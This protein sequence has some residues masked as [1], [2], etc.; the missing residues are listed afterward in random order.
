MPILLAGN[1]KPAVVGGAA[2]LADGLRERAA[3]G[4]QHVG[5]HDPRAGSREHAR[6]GRPLP[7][8]AA[9]DENRLVVEL[10]LHGA[11]PLV[12]DAMGAS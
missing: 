12:L 2:G 3:L 6:L 1:I 7:T 5:D 4:V 9:G 8:A 10:L 11:C